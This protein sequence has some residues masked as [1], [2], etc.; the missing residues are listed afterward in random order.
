MQSTRGHLLTS[1]DILHGPRLDRPRA[2]ACPQQARMESELFLKTTT[3]MTEG[4]RHTARCV[5]F[6]RIHTEIQPR[7]HSEA[8]TSR[9]RYTASD[10][11]GAPLDKTVTPRSADE[12]NRVPPLMPF[13]EFVDKEGHGRRQLVASR[14]KPE[15]DYAERLQAVARRGNDANK[16]RA[17][18]V[19][20]QALNVNKT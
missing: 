2:S 14:L 16:N 13:T 9:K 3:T 15:R 19:F 6:E 10:P 17:T 4:Q 12:Q 7:V 8:A 18:A 11:I 5:K 1:R 20:P